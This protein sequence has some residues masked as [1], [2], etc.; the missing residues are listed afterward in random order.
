MHETG[1]TPGD[2][3]GGAELEERSAEHSAECMRDAPH[4]ATPSAA[5]RHLRTFRT[6]SDLPFLVLNDERR[7]DRSPPHDDDAAP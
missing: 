3:T 1:D 5:D 7:G 6:G 4:D 2:E